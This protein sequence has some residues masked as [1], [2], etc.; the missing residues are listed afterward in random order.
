MAGICSTVATSSIN[1]RDNQPCSSWAM[2]SAANT[3]DCFW[4]AGYLTTSRAILASASADSMARAC[5]TALKSKVAPRPKTKIAKCHPTLGVNQPEFL[6]ER[7][8][9]RVCPR[10]DLNANRGRDRIRNLEFVLREK[11]A[12]RPCNVCDFDAVGR[13]IQPDRVFDHRAHM[14]HRRVFN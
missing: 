14:S 1:S 6:R 4:S 3:A 13:L 11:C 8:N 7:L 5:G 10:L 9:A 12:R 2:A